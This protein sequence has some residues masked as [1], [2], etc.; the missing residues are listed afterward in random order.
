MTRISIVHFTAFTA[1]ACCI[2]I[3]R[4]C[5]SDDVRTIE[6]ILRDEMAAKAQ[7][8]GQARSDAAVQLKLPIQPVASVPKNLPEPS[9]ARSLQA[10]DRIRA[11]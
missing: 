3:G 11:D 9:R 2:L 8:S 10:P 7:Q 4:L 5:G 1:S 6:Q